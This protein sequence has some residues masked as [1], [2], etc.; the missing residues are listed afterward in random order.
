MVMAMSLSIHRYAWFAPRT[1]GDW[2][3]KTASLLQPGKPVLT[4]LGEA[5]VRPAALIWKDIMTADA[6]SATM[7]GPDDSNVEMR[8]RAG[9][10]DGRNHTCS[11]GQWIDACQTCFLWEH[12]P[13]Q[14][15]LELQALCSRCGVF[16]HR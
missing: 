2:L 11:G 5:Y 6:F 13:E 7:E 12:H 9:A 16:S 10:D 15:R 14:K 3:G 1:S 8:C 4:L